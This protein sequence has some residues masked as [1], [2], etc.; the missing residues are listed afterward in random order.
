M[1]F[2]CI[3]RLRYTPLEEAKAVSD[4]KLIETIEN[5]KKS[6]PSNLKEKD[7]KCYTAEGSTADDSSHLQSTVSELSERVHFL[8]LLLMDVLKIGDTKK[9][10][11]KQ[12]GKEEDDLDIL[13]QLGEKFVA[14][15]LVID[16]RNA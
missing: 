6:R 7:S 5:F 9:T 16:N 12:V 1:Y 4:V 8:E 3:V 15:K 14:M 13:K 10:H 2:S 11:S